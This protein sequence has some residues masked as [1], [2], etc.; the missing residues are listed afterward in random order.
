M[1]DIQLF[2][3]LNLLTM[4]EIPE[5]W[6]RSEPYHSYFGDMPITREQAKE[7]ER[8]A[9]VFE[10]AVKQYLLLLLLSL[11]T[12][13][14]MY[15]YAEE[16]LRDTLREHNIGTEDYRARYARDLTRST[17]ANLGTPWFFSED[18]AIWN[19]E[20]EA[21]T[22]SNH[23]DFQ[24]AKERGYTRKRWMGMDDYRERAT[25]KQKNYEIIPIDDYFH[26]GAAELLYPKDIFSENS[27]GADHPEETVN[28]RCS[29][30]YLP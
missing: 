29:L 1:D 5:S 11:G 17:L 28:C 27:T 23:D 12:G 20:N 18:R 30:I 13:V 8:M 10:D 15:E 16:K 25:H 6:K 9:M 3:R 26:V 19:A 24:R 4:D 14:V 2:D 21:N 22:V 7:R